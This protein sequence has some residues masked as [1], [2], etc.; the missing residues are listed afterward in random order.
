LQVAGGAGVGAWMTAVLACICFVIFLLSFRFGTKDITRFDV[1]F[2]AL[3]L[4]SLVLWLVAD[5]P[6]LSVVLIVA[7]DVFGMVPTVRKSWHE[8]YSET[9]V[10]YQITTFRHALS[11]FA[12]EQINIL[13]ALYP[14][15]WVAANGA[16]SAMLMYRRRA[17]AQHSAAL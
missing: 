1:V 12:L 15:A 3:A 10:M 9:L 2:L 14:V 4:I 5:Q 11:F 13:T 17:I 16:F 8:P 6:V 7:T